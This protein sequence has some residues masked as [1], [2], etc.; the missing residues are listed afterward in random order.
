MQKTTMP[1]EIEVWYLIPAIRKELARTLVSDHGLN[2]KKVSEYLN[3]KRASRIKFSKKES[4]IIKKSAEKLLEK[5][6][7]TRVIYD[8]CKILRDSKTICTVH[9]SRDKSIPRNCDVCFE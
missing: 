8:L 7:V 1:Q 9:K 6:N 3:K 2:Q 5:K 4:E